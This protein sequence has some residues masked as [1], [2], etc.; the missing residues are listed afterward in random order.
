MNKQVIT[1]NLNVKVNGKTILR[2]LNLEL[3]S[4]N[5]VLLRGSTGS[6]KTTLLRVLSGLIP[7]FY[8]GFQISGDVKVYGFTTTIALRKGII[9]YVPQDPY[10]YFVGSTPMEEL[11]LLKLRRYVHWLMDKDLLDKNL[12]QLSDG[13]LYLFLVK[14]AYLQNAKLLLLDEPTSH[15]DAL[16]YNYVF[17]LMKSYAQ[18]NDSIVVVVDHRDD[19]ARYADYVI[20]LD[21]THEKCD[22][23]LPLVHNEP[24]DISVVLKNFSCNHAKQ[25]ILKPINLEINRGEAIAIYG[26]NGSGKT[27][28]IWGVACT[29]N[30]EGTRIMKG[31]VFIIP[32]TPIYWF[33]N[34]PVIELLMKF[35]KRKT[36]IESITEQF[37]LD[38]NLMS[39][40]LSIGKSR[41]LSLALAYLS[42]KDIILIDE[43]TLGLDCYAKK[44]LLEIIQE[45][46]KEGKS[47]IVA[48][49][50]MKFAMSFEKKYSLN[51]G[52]LM[53]MQ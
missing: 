2:D 9:A 29:D 1:R 43:P 45:R 51:K 25:R 41:M 16:T 39:Y 31:E 20:N 14:L 44:T 32:Q 11:S 18:T 35:N 21:N 4:G 5:L 36:D 6:G 47:I 24:R 38:K 23:G 10:S 40:N 13:Q 30:C 42:N 50:D 8:R 49:H 22:A 34:A 53:E 37:G 7:E 27:T 48:T 28:F 19:V 15:L 17:E 3:E 33:D 46:I 12:Y 52:V 26:A